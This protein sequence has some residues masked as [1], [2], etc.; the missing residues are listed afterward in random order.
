VKRKLDFLTK[1]A[2]IGTWTENHGKSGNASDKRIF[3]TSY[4]GGTGNN[5]Y[6][7]ANLLPAFSATSGLSEKGRK[8]EKKVKE[9]TNTNTANSAKKSQFINLNQP[10]QQVLFEFYQWY[11][12]QVQSDASKNIFPTEDSIQNWYCLESHLRNVLVD[13]KPQNSIDERIKLSVLVDEI[14][15]QA[16]DHKYALHMNEITGND[17]V[18]HR[19]ACQLLQ[20]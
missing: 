14:E 8:H 2:K 16:L 5:Q 12:H 3:C 7:R 17:L 4:T 11:M 18:A 13:F 15:S 1:N 19:I 10:I 9:M 20:R 6:R